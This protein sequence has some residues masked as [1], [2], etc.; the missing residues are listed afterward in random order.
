[1]QHKFFIM[2]KKTIF[3]YIGLVVV[4]LGSVFAVKCA[5]G[6]TMGG[7]L[8]FGNLKA[9][10]MAVPTDAADSATKGYVDAQIG[11]GGT[12][13]P[14]GLYGG[15]RDGYNYRL[16][17]QSCWGGTAPAHCDISTHYC[18]CDSGYSLLQTGETEEYYF[19]SVGGN[20]PDLHT[21]RILY[22]Y[23]CYKQ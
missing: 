23:S 11:G 8:D 9:I 10:N 16:Y 4:I 13:V 7:N 20:D 3:L 19:G 5:L 1:M 15:C 22:W 6:V 18:Y 12:P 2:T 14:T 17:Q 21:A